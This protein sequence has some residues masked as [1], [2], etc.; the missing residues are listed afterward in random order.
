MKGEIARLLFFAGFF[1]CK[2]SVFDKA[3]MLAGMGVKELRAD[4]I[5]TSLRSDDFFVPKPSP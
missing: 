3:L 2:Y 4:Q 1:I 5:T